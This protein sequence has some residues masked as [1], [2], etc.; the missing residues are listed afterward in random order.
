MQALI[1]A[2]QAVAGRDALDIF[3]TAQLRDIC[4]AAARGLAGR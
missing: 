1:K 3:N 2:A 4:L